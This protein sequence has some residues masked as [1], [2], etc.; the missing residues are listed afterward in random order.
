MRKKLTVLLICVL[1]IPM[2][3]LGE[4]VTAFGF[5]FDPSAEVVDLDALG[6]HVTEIEPVGELI[7]QMPNLK[8]IDMYNSKLKKSQMDALFDGY[9]DIFFGWTFTIWPHVIRTDQTAFSTLHGHEPK[10]HDPFHT[11]N[12]FSMM[13]YC[14]N[15]QALDIGHNFVTDLDFLTD[16]PQLKVLILGANYSCGS[17]AP[18]AALTELEYLEIFST[19]CNDVSPL[20]GMTK[21]KD[22]NIAGNWQLRDISP[23][24]DLPSL[25]RFWAYNI[26]C[27]DEQRA[28]MEAAHPDCEFDWINN[29]TEGTWRTHPR[30]DTI[31]QIFHENRYIPFSE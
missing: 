16:M 30:Y 1:L 2:I 13:R 6:I 22:L 11:S 20:A 17:L 14:K 31:F 28:E 5:E 23:L 29:P 8:E 24:Y 19:Q 25:E 10:E 18:L 12:Q 7:A 21:L 26:R 4:T 9:P 15:M 27:S 3:A